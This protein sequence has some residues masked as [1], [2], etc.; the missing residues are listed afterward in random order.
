MTT[1]TSKNR[2]NPPAN[3]SAQ[4]LLT[5]PIFSDICQLF[6]LAQ[7]RSWPTIA[8][9][10]SWCQGSTFCFVENDALAADGSY[11]EAFI[12]ETKTIP[13]R[14]ENWHDIFGAL[15][16]C[17][18]PKSKALLNQLHMNEIALHGLKQRSRLRN[19]LTLLDECGVI[20]ALQPTA[21]THAD[22]LRQHQWQ[23]S[24]WQQRA[25]WGQGITPII[26]GHA[27][28]EM[29]T[30]PF[31]GLTAKS[32]FIEVPAGFHDWSLTDTY[33]FLDEKLAQQI[34]N[35]ASL[36][37]NQQLTPLPLLGIPGWYAA[38]ATPA[39]YS[40]TEYFR[41]LRQP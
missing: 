22:W 32:W 34:A 2:F 20:L 21:L 24:F 23:Q 7:Q 18:F 37:D 15:I 25:A 1:K 17:L 29:A 40:N 41:P 27:L 4:Y 39:F 14:A 33:T 28:Y 6:P 26:F 5:N 31:L 8:E 16:W 10:N 38:N 11:Y 35:T 9:L 36:L 19:K 3:W 12:Y 13:T 30:Q